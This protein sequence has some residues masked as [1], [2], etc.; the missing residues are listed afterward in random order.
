MRN[1][2]SIHTLRHEITF[3]HM[4]F[5]L[6]QQEHDSAANLLGNMIQSAP[7]DKWATIAATSLWN[8]WSSLETEIED[9][10]MYMVGKQILENLTEYQYA[11][12]EYLHIATQTAE[13]AFELYSTEHNTEIGE[14]AL[15]ISRILVAQK[16]LIVQI[17]LL[18][19]II[20]TELG[21]QEVALTRWKTI[22]SGSS[23]G[24]L[25]WLQARYNIVLM[26]SNSS[27]ESALA[28]LNQHH[29]LYPNYGKD[30]Y[31][32]KLKELHNRL[33]ERGKSES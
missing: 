7:Q 1:T 5:F 18:N 22:A 27:E 26:L 33:M 25:L 32:S 28:V 17:L 20:E 6:H 10:L 12:K 8:Y 23:K 3:R 2:Y 19:A 30:P 4:M 21:D 31:G 9:E 16:P 29:A 24:S 11:N 15:R 13:A 14:E